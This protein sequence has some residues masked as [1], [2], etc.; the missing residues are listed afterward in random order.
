MSLPERQRNRVIQL[1]R[2]GEVENRSRALLPRVAVVQQRFQTA[3]NARVAERLAERVISL[4]LNAP[5]RA[6]PHFELQPMIVRVPDVR[7]DAR[8]EQVRIGEEAE[9]GIQDVVVLLD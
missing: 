1:E 7:Q 6:V 2:M 5:R 3:Q 9:A 4:E 8:V